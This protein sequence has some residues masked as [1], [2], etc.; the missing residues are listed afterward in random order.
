MVGR[1]E[2]GSLREEYAFDVV[3]SCLLF[4]LYPFLYPILGKQFVKWQFR[5]V[6]NKTN[7]TRLMGVLFAGFKLVIFQH[8]MSNKTG[9]LTSHRG[10]SIHQVEETLV[11]SRV[12]AIGDLILLGSETEISKT[13]CFYQR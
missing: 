6:L 2:R 3:H 10:S 12:Y 13:C 8:G 9:A 1:L 5:R 7:V 11:K 4:F